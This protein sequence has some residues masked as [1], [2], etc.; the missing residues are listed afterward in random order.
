MDSYLFYSHILILYN[1]EFCCDIFMYLICFCSP[2]P[3]R[4]VTLLITAS[5]SIPFLRHM[6][7]EVLFG[8]PFFNVPYKIPA[9][10]SFTKA[11][12]TYEWMCHYMSLGQVWWHM[13][14]GP[15][16]S[17]TGHSSNIPIINPSLYNLNLHQ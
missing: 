8:D 3:P 12:A 1:N 7:S 6:L 11:M 2:R 5:Q 13:P 16:L 9:E 17:H 15:A 10:G 4:L 14:L